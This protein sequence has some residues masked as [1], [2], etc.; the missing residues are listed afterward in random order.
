[1]SL[2]T[3]EPL[4]A[5]HEILYGAVA[6]QGDLDA[7]I[8]NPISST[9]LKWLRFTVVSWRHDFQPFTA[10]VWNCLIVGLLWLHHLQN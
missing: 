5:F 10:M 8:F 9:I 1:V 4:G 6:S 7:I 2:I 3:F